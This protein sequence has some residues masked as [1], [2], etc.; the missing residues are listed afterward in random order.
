M[1]FT[2]AFSLVA[3][4]S[5][6]TPA[7]AQVEN[8]PSVATPNSV[9]L[10]D[11]TWVE[12][13]DGVAAGKTT[14]IIPTGGT[15]QNGP[16]MVIGKHNYLVKYKAGEIAKLLG[17]AIVAPVMAYV[18]EGEIPGAKPAAGHM[19]FPGTITTPEDA[20]E[21]VLE[22][23]ARSLKSAGFLDIAFI[24]DSGGN[25][26]G[27]KAV[28]EMLN[29]EWAGTNV[30]VHHISDYYPG[31][32]DDIAAAHGM[33]QEAIGSHAGSQDVTSLMYINPGMLRFDKFALGKA[34]DGQGH[35]GDPRF[36]TANIGR[37]ILEAQIQD[38]ANQI[39]KLRVSSRQ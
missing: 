25:Q 12:V 30:R 24:G 7:I 32:G 28:S 38:G 9:F 20:Y 3:L 37:L 29:K 35:V 16:I 10:E 34:N 11:L 27:Q 33:S 13:R 8:V 19:R 21:K 36:A 5:S 6:T 39:K 2:L 26:A 31:R 17:N 4:V 1:R 14:V 23:A 15:E 18:P 22:Y